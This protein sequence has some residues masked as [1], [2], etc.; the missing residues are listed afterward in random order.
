MF[1]SFSMKRLISLVSPLG[2]QLVYII[3]VIVYRALSHFLS[4]ESSVFQMRN[5]KL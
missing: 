4:V 5:E 3:F 1:V 2:S